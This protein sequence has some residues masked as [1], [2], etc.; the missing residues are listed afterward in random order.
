MKV[1]AD[2]GNSLGWLLHSG[3]KH[4][5]NTGADELVAMIYDGSYAVLASHKF[6]V[7]GDV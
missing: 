4:D 6:A 3:K 2:M 5:V 7:E 1:S